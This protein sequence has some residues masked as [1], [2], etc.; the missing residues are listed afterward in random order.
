MLTNVG[1][2]QPII[3]KFTGFTLSRSLENI[4]DPMRTAVGAFRYFAPVI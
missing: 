3:Y 2:N 4:H 1:D